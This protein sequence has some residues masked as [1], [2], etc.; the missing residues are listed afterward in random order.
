MVSQNFILQLTG[1]FLFLLFVR[2]FCSLQ[3]LFVRIFSDFFFF[4]FFLFSLF[5]LTF[6]SYHFTAMGVILGDTKLSEVAKTALTD[7]I[8]HIKIVILVPDVHV[9]FIVRIPKLSDVKN[10]FEENMAINQKG[11]LKQILVR[12]VHEVDLVIWMVTD[13]M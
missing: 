8:L 4:T 11:L 1:F 5:F 13:T 12:I 6:F 7:S 3:H 10:A 2:I 9:V